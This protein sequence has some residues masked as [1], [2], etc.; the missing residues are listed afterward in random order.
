[1]EGVKSKVVNDENGEP[2]VTGVSGP[3]MAGTFADYKGIAVEDDLPYGVGAVILSLIETS[4]LPP[5]K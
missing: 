1:M 5:G 2:K 3:T 4:G